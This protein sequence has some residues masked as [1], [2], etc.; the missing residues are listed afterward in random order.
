MNPKSESPP[1]PPTPPVNKLSLHFFSQQASNYAR[2]SN[3]TFNQAT[4]FFFRVSQGFEL[5]D[6]AIHRVVVKRH[7]YG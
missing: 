4:G 5:K 3:C 6:R 1:H 2:E 7:T